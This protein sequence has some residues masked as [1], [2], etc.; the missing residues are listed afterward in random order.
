MNFENTHLVLNPVTCISNI[1]FLF[2]HYV[3]L[4]MKHSILQNLDSTKQIAYNFLQ[5]Y[6]KTNH[7]QK[8][9]RHHMQMIDK[10]RL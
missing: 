8:K 4:S 10:I 3:K 7:P 6:I 5:T 1:I 2:V 9:Y